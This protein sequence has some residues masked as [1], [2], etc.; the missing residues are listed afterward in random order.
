MRQSCERIAT[1]LGLR[2]GSGAAPTHNL[3]QV[4]VSA[5]HHESNSPVRETINNYSVPKYA[6]MPG[7]A[8]SRNQRG[9]DGQPSGYKSLREKSPQRDNTYAPDANPVGAKN[10]STMVRQSLLDLKERL[11]QVRREKDAMDRSLHL[12]DAHNKK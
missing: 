10:T 3:Q 2:E 5:V 11:G 8:A 1:V 6:P 4:R 7:N 9:E 12:F